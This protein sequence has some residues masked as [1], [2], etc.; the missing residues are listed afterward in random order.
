MVLK[1]QVLR[2]LAFWVFVKGSLNLVTGVSCDIA[3]IFGGVGSCYFSWVFTRAFFCA[4][5]YGGVSVPG[6][7]VKT[8]VFISAQVFSALAVESAS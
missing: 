4:R 8:Q 5:V 6:N 2:P 3:Y 7:F 1:F